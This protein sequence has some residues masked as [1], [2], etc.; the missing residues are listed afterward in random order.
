MGIRSILSNGTMP[1]GRSSLSWLKLPRSWPE[2]SCILKKLS[3]HTLR[4]PLVQVGH[5][6]AHHIHV[7]LDEGL[8]HIAH[9][10]RLHL[11]LLALEVPH[12]LS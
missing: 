5:G 8:R 10:H 4:E 1:T 6:L 3:R 2:G 12:R 11:I 9:G 7:A